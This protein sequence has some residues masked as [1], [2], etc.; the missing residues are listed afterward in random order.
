MRAPLWLPHRTLVWNWTLMRITNV[1]QVS[2][3]CKK[4]IDPKAPFSYIY[5]YPTFLHNQFLV[6]STHRNHFHLLDESY[7]RV[8][9]RN[10]N[11]KAPF[12]YVYSSP[13]FL[14]NQCS[15]V[16]VYPEKPSSP[17]W[18]DLLTCV[19]YQRSASMSVDLMATFI[20]ISLLQPSYITFH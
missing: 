17:H 4:S 11:L 15:L 6:F 7:S 19:I 3:E 12:N 16:F 14:Y 10:A 1:R 13:S 20:C 9:T 8:S 5:S 2:R 18:W